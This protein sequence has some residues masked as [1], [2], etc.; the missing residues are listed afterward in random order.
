MIQ[1][2]MLSHYISEKSKVL[3]LGCGNGELLKYLMTEKKCIGYGIDIEIKNIVSCIEKKIGVFQGDLN[4]GLQGFSDQSYDVVVLSLTLQQIKTPEF[5]IQEMLRVG[6]KVIITFPN[7]AHFK[8]R[9]QFLLGKA[10]KNKSLPYAW[11]NTPNIRVVTVKDFKNLC[12]EMGFKIET[13][14]PLYGTPFMEKIMPKC[15]SNLWCENALFI[16]KKETL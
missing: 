10:P 15:L 1:H 13:E 3:D 12:Q 16:L 5:L 9:L 7:F 6:K 4:D 8:C 14:I 11:Y 2:S